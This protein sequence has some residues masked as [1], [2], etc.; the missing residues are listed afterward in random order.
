M[1]AVAIAGSLVAMSSQQAP[2]ASPAASSTLGIARDGRNAVEFV[3]HVEQVGPKVET[4]GYLTH[5]NGL[6]DASL[7]TAA[8]PLS[9]N[10]K[11]ARFTF[12]GT[13]TVSQ[14]FSVLA[15]AAAGPPASAPSAFDTDSRGTLTFYFQQPGADRTFANPATFMMGAAVAGY[16][17]RFQD[18]IAALVGVDPNR[19]VLSGTGELCQRSL[20]SFTLAGHTYQ[21]G[22]AHLF[23]RFSTHGWSVRTGITPAGPTSFTNLGGNTEVFRSAGC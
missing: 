21:L 14:G 7:F 9:R 18:T 17:V 5:I 3:G 19:G 22:R 13:A 6:A 23:Q 1:I 20:K 10:E 15:G 12:H 2:A 16:T 11:T 8:S 4:Y